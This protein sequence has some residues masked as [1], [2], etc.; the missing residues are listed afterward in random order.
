M[1]IKTQEHQVSEEE[2]ET[3]NDNYFSIGQTE[4]YYS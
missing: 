4:S 1:L 3:S 2:E